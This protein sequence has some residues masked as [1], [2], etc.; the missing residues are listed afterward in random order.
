MRIGSSVL[1]T[2]VLVT[3]S[4]AAIAGPALTVPEPETLALLAVGAIA[5]VVA[6]WRMR[7]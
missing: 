7:K 1:L 4:G 2:A 6:R 3:L 5:L